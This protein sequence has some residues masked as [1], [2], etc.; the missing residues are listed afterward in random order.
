MDCLESASGS[1]VSAAF[2]RVFDDPIP[3][4]HR[5]ANKSGRIKWQHYV[6][7]SRFELV[8]MELMDSGG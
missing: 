7:W 2:E 8:R 3:A 5:E 4:E 1:E 6:A